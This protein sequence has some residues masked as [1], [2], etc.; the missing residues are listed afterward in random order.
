MWQECVVKIG[1]SVK[2]GKSVLLI[3][4]F[5]TILCSPTLFLHSM[6]IIV[7]RCG[8]RRVCCQMRSAVTSLKWLLLSRRELSL[9]IQMLMSRAIIFLLR[10]S[11]FSAIIIFPSLS[12]SFHPSAS[13]LRPPL[14]LLFC[15]CVP[16]L[17]LLR[18][19][20]L[21]PIHSTIA[22]TFPSTG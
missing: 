22:S 16:R 1:K 5:S 21:R 17:G 14:L 15:K 12:C 6:C 20:P 13:F 9:I 18:I 19:G 4:K 3:V 7:T 2:C 10:L 8:K 11:C